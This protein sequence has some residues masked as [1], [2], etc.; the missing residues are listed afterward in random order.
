[1]P[2]HCW[3]RRGCSESCPHRSGTASRAV[4]APSG[5]E[6][7][8]CQGPLSL[9]L[10][11]LFPLYCVLIEAESSPRVP[12]LPRHSPFS[13]LELKKGSLLWP[14]GHG[15]WG[16]SQACPG[17]PS[18]PR[19]SWQGSLLPSYLEPFPHSPPLCHVSRPWLLSRGRCPCTAWLLQ[20]DLQT[21]TA[22]SVLP[23]T[24]PRTHSLANTHGP[25]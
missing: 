25:V 20:G 7:S 22:L 18:T 21:F 14:Q 24:P 15:A 6:D 4:H 13:R 9:S 3:R 2:P 10:C 5:M 19:G 11:S 23:R 16:W 8:G 12:C 1:M 17:Q